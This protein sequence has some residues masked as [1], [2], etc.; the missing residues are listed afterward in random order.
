MAA[1]E[2]HDRAEERVT[3]RRTLPVKLSELPLD[4]RLRAARE[5]GRH[6]PEP[7]KLELLAAAI[8]PRPEH[9]LHWVCESAA[10]MLEEM[11]AA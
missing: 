11:R 4:I 2:G 6:E 3:S 10:G 9:D 7:E 5:A 1:L 8:H